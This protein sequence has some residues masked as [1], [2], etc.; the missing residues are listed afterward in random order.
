MLYLV[1]IDP[2]DQLLPVIVV[3]YYYSIKAEMGSDA[4][5]ASLLL[6]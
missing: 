2:N 6:T 3:N 4:G 5:G 1:E